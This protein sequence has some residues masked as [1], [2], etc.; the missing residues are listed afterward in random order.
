MKKLALFLMSALALAVIAIV[1]FFQWLLN[2]FAYELSSYNSNV[3]VFL[4]GL[5][6]I[7]VTRLRSWRFS[8]RGLT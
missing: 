3:F 1:P 6:G 8:G 7:A 5:I 4:V 2:T